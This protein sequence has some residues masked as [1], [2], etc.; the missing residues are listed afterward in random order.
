LSLLAD[1]IRIFYDVYDLMVPVKG[2]EEDHVFISQSFDPTSH[3]ET[4]MNDVLAMYKR[5]TG[6]EA[7]LEES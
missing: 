6:K 3:F 2:G 7:Q 5:I 4:A 1:N